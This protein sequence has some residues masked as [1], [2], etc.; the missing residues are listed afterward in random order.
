MRTSNLVD[1]PSFADVLFEFLTVVLPVSNLNPN[2]SPNP[3]SDVSPSEPKVT[4]HRTR[5]SI[6]SAT[7][8]T[9]DEPVRPH[10]SH[11]PYPLSRSHSAI[12]IPKE[13]S[14]PLSRSH[15]LSGHSKRDHLSSGGGRPRK[16]RTSMVAEREE[17]DRG[18][19]LDQVR[20][21]QSPRIP[22]PG[23]LLYE[24]P[25][26]FAGPSP[27]LQPP[28]LLYSQPP[29]D[30]PLDNRRH[31]HEGTPYQA[32]RLIQEG[33]S[34]SSQRM[35][36][37]PSE[38]A[39]SRSRSQQNEPS[40]ASPAMIKSRSRNI[41]AVMGSIAESPQHDLAPSA[42]IHRQLQVQVHP[43]HDFDPYQYSADYPTPSYPPSHPQYQPPHSLP[44]HREVVED[45]HQRQQS[46]HDREL[47][48]RHEQN[49]QAQQHNQFLLDRDL[50]AQQVAD[51][52]MA[53]QQQQYVEDQRQHQQ[54]AFYY[55]NDAPQ[56]G[57]APE[58]TG[59]GLMPSSFEM[60]PQGSHE[61]VELGLGG[62]AGA[63]P[64]IAAVEL[65]EQERRKD[66]SRRYDEIMYGVQA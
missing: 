23:S 11:A 16:A 4:R 2:P 3:T 59:Y 52:Q 32:P 64:D 33:S 42:P 24:Y 56:Q 43:G 63:Y 18:Y 36:H 1:D 29:R 25:Q 58:Q 38:G 47:L 60:V 12:D 35:Q 6:A 37:S 22:I 13:S 55:S 8:P 61:M 65:F 40:F 45:H 30:E 34:A 27:P 28:I 39:Y 7:L 62:I 51:H 17:H 26:H 5:R 19:H 15:S 14:R 21:G 41:G 50:E 54:A 31:S 20:E 9:P 57:Y 53:L 10:A 49:L 44:A 46:R 66:S 48:R